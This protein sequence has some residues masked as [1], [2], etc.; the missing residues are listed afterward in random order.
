MMKYFIDI[1]YN[2]DGVTY[3]DHS[4]WIDNE[5]DAD[6]WLWDQSESIMERYYFKHEEDKVKFI[7]R[8]L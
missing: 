8:W 1:P 7:L 6:H 2:G 3:W 5:I 4:E